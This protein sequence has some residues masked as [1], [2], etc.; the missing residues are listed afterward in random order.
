MRTSDMFAAM[1]VLTFAVPAPVAA[2]DSQVPFTGTVLSTCLLTVGTPGVLTT[3]ADYTSFS[4]ANAGGISGIV[5][6]VTTGIG[7]EVSTIA[8]TGFTLKPTGGDDNVTFSTTYTA[9]GATNVGETAGTT[10]TT[11]GLGA[12]ILT[13]NLGAVKSVGTFTA[14]AY[15]TTVTVRCE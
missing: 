4:S 9:N 5:T 11:L 1:A 13:V 14:G 7:Y 6:A 2:F 15:A 3:N 12:T 10:A 8:P